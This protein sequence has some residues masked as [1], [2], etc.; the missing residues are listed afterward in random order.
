MVSGFFTTG[1]ELYCYSTIYRHMVTN[2]LSVRDL[3]PG[4]IFRKRAKQNV[5]NLTGH[6]VQFAVEFF[7]LLAP[8]FYASAFS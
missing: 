4:I 6:V 3:L 5:I 1:F 8:F 2:N 7:F